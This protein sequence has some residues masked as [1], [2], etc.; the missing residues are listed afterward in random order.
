[1]KTE[2]IKLERS[3][4]VIVYWL[5][6]LS[7]RDL[8]IN[9]VNSYYSPEIHKKDYQYCLLVEWARYF[10][11]NSASSIETSVDSVT[12]RSAQYHYDTFEQFVR[13]RTFN[14]VP[15][16]VTT[17][18]NGGKP[19]EI[20]T[21]LFDYAH[22]KPGQT[23]ADVLPLL[24]RHPEDAATCQFALPQAAKNVPPHEAVADEEDDDIE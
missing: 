19:V 17:Q 16:V 6:T 18:M 13:I 9:M 14:F 21:D 11:G 1:M 24:C 15:D 7:R 5:H 4:S 8:K 23:I 12:I 3:W 10:F 22:W 20:V 2:H